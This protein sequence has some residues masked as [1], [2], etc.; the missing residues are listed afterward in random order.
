[1]NTVQLECFM[2]VSACLNFSRAAE[3]LRMTQPA[4]SHQINSL[5]SEL[6]TKLFN[7]TSK[8]VELT[9]DG[10]RF[11][12][13]ASDA[14]KILNTAKAKISDKGTAEVLPLGITCRNIRIS[15]TLPPVL[16]RVAKELPLCRPVVKISP[17]MPVTALTEN[18]TV[19]VIFSYKANAPAHSRIIYKEL[20]KCRLCC[21][22]APG[23]ELACYDSLKT[24]DLKGKSIALISRQ[25]DIPEVYKVVTDAS[26]A[27]R[28]SQIYL[29][30]NFECAKPLVQA[31]LC[32]CVQPDLPAEKDGSLK[33]IPISDSA[34]VSFGVYY[35]TLKSNPVLKRFIEIT[36]NVFVEGKK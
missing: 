21:V 15:E 25:R 8:S 24:D 12:G 33:Y 4:V 2:E 9:R 3:N 29:C 6:G 18:E 16:R 23:S 34:P 27:L 14:L 11:I 30:D 22:C 26:A 10:I 5:E 32:F 13:P 31:G 1:M 35:S 36:L 20:K 17:F 28:Q 19:D 7:R